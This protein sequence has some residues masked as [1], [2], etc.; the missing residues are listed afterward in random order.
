M[1]YLTLRS[2]VIPAKGVV[3][4]QRIRPQYLLSCGMF[5]NG[6]RLST[7]KNCFFI[8]FVFTTDIPYQIKQKTL[9]LL[10]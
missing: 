3:F 7:V 10:T 9:L 4:I 8:E 2:G 6:L 1:I 5:S